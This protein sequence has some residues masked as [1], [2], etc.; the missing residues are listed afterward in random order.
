M[1]FKIG[2]I[3]FNHDSL[4]G[5]LIADEVGEI[6]EIN[7][8][9]LLR[10][11]RAGRVL[12]VEK[13]SDLMRP[14]IK[15]IQRSGGVGTSRKKGFSIRQRKELLKIHEEARGEIY[16][17]IK[18]YVSMRKILG[19]EQDNGIM[20]IEERINQLEL[21]IWKGDMEKECLLDLMDQMK[22]HI[23]KSHFQVEANGKRRA[24]Q[25]L[26]NILKIVAKDIGNIDSVYRKQIQEK[27]QQIGIEIQRLKNIT[28]ISLFMIHYRKTWALMEKVK[29]ELS[30]LLLLQKAD[31]EKERSRR[32]FISAE[33]AKLDQGILNSYERRLAERPWYIQYKPLLSAR[34]YLE[35]CVVTGE[36]GKKL[37]VDDL[38]ISEEKNRYSL[39][40]HGRKYEFNGTM[41]NIRL[42]AGIMF[43]ADKEGIGCTDIMIQFRNKDKKVLKLR[44]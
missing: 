12:E 6:R 21:L 20:L 1:A 11:I 3:Y 25:K 26:M 37:G 27:V 4:I 40:Y 13:S 33:L 41:T 14:D 35:N 34:M 7:T 15:R 36:S 22:E 2:A 17:L 5:S 9:T 24:V 18:K 42:I 23:I 32:R 28:D 29:A 38:L 16:G 30:K 8:E 43:V 39:E 19:L 10:L 44:S 31:L